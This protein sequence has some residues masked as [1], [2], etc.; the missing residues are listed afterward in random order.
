MWEKYLQSPIK[1]HNNHKIEIKIFSIPHMDAIFIKV[2]TKNHHKFRTVYRMHKFSPQFELDIID[3]RA[4]LHDNLLLDYAAW[5]R[6]VLK[7]SWIWIRGRNV[8]VQK[9]TLCPSLMHTCTSG[10][11][12]KAFAARNE[13]CC[14]QNFLPDKWTTI[15]ACTWSLCHVRS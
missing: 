11:F 2:Y 12:Y 5:F 4:T 6:R 14:N 3:S 8:H 7:S 1:F 10:K 13:L 15:T 9:W